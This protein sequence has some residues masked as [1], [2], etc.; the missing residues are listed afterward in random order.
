MYNPLHG[1]FLF[2]E[3]SLACL[4]DKI[5]VM[6]ENHYSTSEELQATLQELTDLQEIVH[7]INKDNQQLSEENKSLVDSTKTQNS[8]MERL[9]L[10]SRTVIVTFCS[11]RC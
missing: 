2:S 3:V 5:A 1:K 11:C 10:V 4:Q 8:K 7:E 9:R 6:E